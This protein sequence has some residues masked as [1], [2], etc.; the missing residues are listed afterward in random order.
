MRAAFTMQTCSVLA[1]A[2][3]VRP[4]SS[5]VCVSR[6]CPDIVRECFSLTFLHGTG[7]EVTVALSTFRLALV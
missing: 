3:S 1:G 7:G 5:T 2:S 4:K 6:I